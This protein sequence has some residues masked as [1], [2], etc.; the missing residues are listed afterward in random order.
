MNVLDKKFELSILFDYY[1][2]LLT[3][4]QKIVMQSYLYDDLDMVEIAENHN[5]SKQAVHDSLKNA[6]NKLK[7]YEMNLRCIY[8]NDVFKADLIKILR[9]IES[10]NFDADDICLQLKKIIDEI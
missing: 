1:G 3:D 10:K 6:I 8:K 2:V 5:I 7:M 9:D 4:K